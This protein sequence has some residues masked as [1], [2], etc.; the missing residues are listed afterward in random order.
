M[1]LYDGDF[2]RTVIINTFTVHV[3]KLLAGT[4]LSMSSTYCSSL[5]YMDEFCSKMVIFH[6]AE[7]LDPFLR[8]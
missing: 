6:Q 3:M 8:K 2:Q 1:V 7:L 5:Y 4:G